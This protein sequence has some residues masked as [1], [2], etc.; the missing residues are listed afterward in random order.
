MPRSEGTITPIPGARPLRPG[1]LDGFWPQ[2]KHDE[3]V[4]RVRYL[5]HDDLEEPPHIHKARQ[6]LKQRGVDWREA[7]DKEIFNILEQL[8]RPPFHSKFWK[9]EP[10]PAKTSEYHDILQ[11][12]HLAELQYYGFDSTS[13]SGKF[14]YNI[15]DA[16]QDPDPSSFYQQLKQ[17]GVSIDKIVHFTRKTARSSDVQLL[18]LPY[19]IEERR[20][21]FL[22]DLGSVLQAIQEA[23]FRPGVIIKEFTFWRDGVDQDAEALVRV[24]WIDYTTTHWLTQYYNV[25]QR[26]PGSGFVTCS[27]TI[28]IKKRRTLMQ[29]LKRSA[30]TLVSRDSSRLR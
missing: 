30:S 4:K 17:A 28:Y 14:L 8:P 11:R 16:K 15:R 29:A 7:N 26:H 22:G 27:P 1:D 19:R 20:E 9:R 2:Q 18:S 21:H 25:F 10:P 23:D 13:P 3:I 5:V 6:I 12:V 24:S